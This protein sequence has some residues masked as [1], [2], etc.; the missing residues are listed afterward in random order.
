MF[1]WSAAAIFI[2]GFRTRGR[3]TFVSAKVPKAIT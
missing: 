3:D 1:V 2:A